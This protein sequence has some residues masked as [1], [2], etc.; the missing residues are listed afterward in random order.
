MNN[1]SVVYV[2]KEE[3]F[4]WIFSGNST[5]NGVRT[6]CLFHCIIGLVWFGLVYLFI[7]SVTYVTLDISIADYNL[8]HIL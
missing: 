3:T 7:C 4:C 1:D 5:D 8:Q 6:K 2:R